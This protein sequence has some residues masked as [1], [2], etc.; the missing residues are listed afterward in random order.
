MA[1]SLVEMAAEIVQAQAASKNMT[2]EELGHALQS[3]FKTLI[4]LQNDE[5]KAVSGGEVADIGIETEL[6]KV[7]IA[8]EKSILKNK[9]SSCF[10]SFS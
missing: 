3:T 1:K 8:P 10:Y 2:T 5:T 9:I 4:S 7:D 6:A